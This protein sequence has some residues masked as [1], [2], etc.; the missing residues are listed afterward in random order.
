MH[1]NRHE[2][3]KKHANQALE[4]SQRFHS[5]NHCYILSKLKYVESALDRR[6]GDYERARECL[7]VSVEVRVIEIHSCSL[8]DIIL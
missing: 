1:E 8:I 3:A 2:D 4:M 6:K 5:P 7:D